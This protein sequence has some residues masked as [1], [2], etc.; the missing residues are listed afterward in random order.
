MMDF[1]ISDGGFFGG[2]YY[3]VLKNGTIKFIQPKKK[4]NETKR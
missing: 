4:N 1:K 2:Y 3:N